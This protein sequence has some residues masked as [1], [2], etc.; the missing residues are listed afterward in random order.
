MR[1][2]FYDAV[3]LVFVAGL[4]IA[5]AAPAAA[6]DCIPVARHA[7]PHHGRVHRKGVPPRRL[8]AHGHVRP[9]SAGSRPVRAA[10]VAAPQGRPLPVSGSSMRKACPAN[11]RGGNGSG[12]GASGPH[13]PRPDG[14]MDI[15]P[16]SRFASVSPISRA[17]GP[18]LAGGPSELVSDA[19]T[20]PDRDLTGSSSLS[21]GPGD[22]GPGGLVPE[23][24][25]PASP[26]SSLTPPEIT[27]PV[28]SAVPE[29]ETWALMI[30]GFALVGLTARRRG[31]AGPG[32]VT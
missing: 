26:I 16:Q 10:S 30:V 27:P 14:S 23:I 19:P 28:A 25:P 1:T 17:P 32:R 22:A 11:H 15:G 29:P 12:A 7:A 2:R 6:S 21:P 31:A 4:T 3:A 18:E 9:I 5:P 24:S 20:T 8:P 13:L